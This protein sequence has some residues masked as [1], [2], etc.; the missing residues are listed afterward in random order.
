MATK[1]ISPKKKSIKTVGTNPILIMPKTT[2]NKNNDDFPIKKI[3]AEWTITDK[4][5]NK[6]NIPIWDSASEL[7]FVYSDD[8]SEL[9]HISSLESVCLENEAGTS[10]NIKT[11]LFDIDGNVYKNKIGITEIL[12]SSPSLGK[13]FKCSIEASQFYR[14]Y[15]EYSEPL[16]L[17]SIE[18]RDSEHPN[19]FEKYF[20]DFSL[21]HQ[22]WNAFHNA[23]LETNKNMKVKIFDINY[24]QELTFDLAI[25]K[26]CPICGNSIKM[27]KS[28]FGKF[29]GCTGWPECKALWNENFVPNQK[30][31]ELL[32]NLT[33]GKGVKKKTGDS[34]NK[35]KEKLEKTEDKKI[36][37]AIANLEL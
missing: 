32:K 23:V 18:V 20:S 19:I 5:G 13:S 36:A 29:W 17:F 26:T 1:K 2:P 16:D 37:Q 11:L 6:T 3:I 30:T 10:E 21:V 28:S 9:E 14:R 33:K 22:F 27:K 24:I 31:K 35:E 12:R 8:F 34:N 15:K 25:N 7:F 4:Q